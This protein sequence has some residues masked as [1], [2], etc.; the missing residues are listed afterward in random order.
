MILTFW[1]YR[2]ANIRLLLKQQSDLG[3]HCLKLLFCLHHLDA[4]LY[5]RANLFKS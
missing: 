2:E 3:L 4:F 1:T 5:G